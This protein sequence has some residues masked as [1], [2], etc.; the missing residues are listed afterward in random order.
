MSSNISR[1]LLYVVTL[2]VV[3][4]FVLPSGALSTT[5][6]ER[7]VDGRVVDDGDGYIGLR[8]NSPLELRYGRNGGGVKQSENVEKSTV[9]FIHI[10]NQLPGDTRIKELIVLAQPSS[11]RGPP[12]FVLPDSLDHPDRIGD[13]EWHPITA[14]IVCGANQDRTGIL[15]FTIRAEGQNFSIQLTRPIKVSCIG[16][17]VNDSATN[18][19]R[20]SQPTEKPEA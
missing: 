12:P 13:D 3:A 5:N 1:P 17:P 20:T 19:T 2:A 15:W 11:R 9:T 4:A 10:R 7:G 16:P 8:M 18:G 6:I 14:S